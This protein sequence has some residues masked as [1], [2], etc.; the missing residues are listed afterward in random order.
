MDSHKA[1]KEFPAI[2]KWKLISTISGSL[3]L[4]IGLLCLNEKI[5]APYDVTKK[6][7]ENLAVLSLTAG[8]FTIVGNI[9]VYQE[10]AK[11]WLDAIGIKQTIAQ[12]GLREVDLDFYA[13]D[14][15]SLIV[16]AKTID[17]LVIHADKWIGNRLNDLRQF[18]SHSGNELRVCLLDEAAHCGQALAEDFHYGE[19]VLAQKI[20]NVEGTLRGSMKDLGKSGK[21]TGRL[22]IWKH[23]LIPKYTYYRFDDTLA[24]VP[25]NQAPGRTPIPAFVFHKQSGGV[26]D[27]LEQQFEQLVGD[28]DLARLVYD[29]EGTHE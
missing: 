25:Y 28:P 5:P 1:S 23:K 8:M 12:S 21:K 2:A 22:R 6:V 14:F 17:I 4:G 20:Q 3:L 15:R 11:F 9:L 26:S 27:F 29:S 18:L 10:L 13:Y 24:F 7:I 16:E 19:G